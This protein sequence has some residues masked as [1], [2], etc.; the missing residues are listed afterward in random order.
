VN[1]ARNAAKAATLSR[2]ASAVASQWISPVPG[3][4]RPAASAHKLDQPH[5]SSGHELEALSHELRR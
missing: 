3:S 1:A 4:Q 2:S 5:R